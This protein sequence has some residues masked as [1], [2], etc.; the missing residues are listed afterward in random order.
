MI[1]FLN[2]LKVV[3]RGVL[4]VPF[5]DLVNIYVTVHFIIVPLKKIIQETEKDKTER[6]PTC[7]LTPQMPPTARA[8][9]SQS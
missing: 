5:L 4:G 7:W 9:S 6:V 2:I 3:P 8:G 1:F